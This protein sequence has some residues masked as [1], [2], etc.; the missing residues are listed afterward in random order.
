MFFR[1]ETWRNVCGLWRS[2][3]EECQEE[4]LM[5]SNSIHKF[6][7]CFNI[8]FSHVSVFKL[9]YPPR[10]EPLSTFFHNPRCLDLKWSNTDD[11]CVCIRFKIYCDP[12]R[13][14]R[15]S[16]HFYSVNKIFPYS[17]II[18][19]CTTNLCNASRT[20]KE[21]LYLRPLKRGL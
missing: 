11:A 1:L 12:N 8:N 18:S 4:W 21:Y 3:H 16:I 13:H 7:I 14:I 19:E 17:K 20:A 6:K 5:I 10:T 2:L 9:P 15:T